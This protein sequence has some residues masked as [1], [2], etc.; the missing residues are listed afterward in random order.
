MNLSRE[1]KIIVVKQIQY[2]FYDR[3]I[4]YYI[5]RLTYYKKSRSIMNST[6]TFLASQQYLFAY[7]KVD[8]S[9]N[10]LLL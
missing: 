2:N 3:K 6:E 7:S 1:K 5:C 4:Q 10:F 9:V 8:T